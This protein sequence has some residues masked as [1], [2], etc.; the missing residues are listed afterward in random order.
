MSRGRS[1]IALIFA[2]LVI[3]VIVV[4]L[5]VPSKGD[6]EIRIGAIFPLSGRYAAM[7]VPLK[8]A[9]DIAVAE[10]NSSGGIEGRMMRV[11]YEDS[12]GVPKDGATAALKLVTID[13]VPVVTSFLTG[14]C[15][16]VKPIAENSRTLFL[17]QTVAPRIH[18]GSKFSLRF[19]YSF[20]EEGRVIREFIISQN[21]R[22]VGIIHSNDPSTS[23]EIDS[24]V[25][26]F[27][28]ERGIVS[29]NESF[30]IGNKDF[31][32]IVQKMIS[33]KVGLIYMAGYGN[34]MPALLNELY[35]N[36][37]NTQ[38]I[39][40]CGNIGFIELPA[41]TP[42]E[43]YEGVVFTIPPFVANPNDS[44]L[45]GFRKKYLETSGEK[46]VGYAAYYAYDM[47]KIL[48][49][50]LKNASSGELTNLR[51]HFVGEFHGICGIYKITPEGDVTPPVALAKYI[52]GEVAVVSR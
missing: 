6:R 36:R 27:L 14:V 49:Q 20:T 17:A 34:D 30:S 8:H 2:F 45:T 48:A 31:S 21:V 38:K 26:P 23:Y 10:V 42:K 52:G 46:Q 37:R 40:L 51:S 9:T 28:S 19:H 47:I 15:E 44:S 3:A 32:A 13:K 43:L 50:A 35:K 12:K 22:R 41:G 4:V 29:V 33:S 11:L 25:V 1:I 5:I 24:V 18:V 16:A 39:L 7:G